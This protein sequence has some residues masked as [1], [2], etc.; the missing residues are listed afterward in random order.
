M[1]FRY[2]NFEDPTGQRIGWSGSFAAGVAI[3]QV[4]PDLHVEKA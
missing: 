4:H 1:Q 2:F 3:N